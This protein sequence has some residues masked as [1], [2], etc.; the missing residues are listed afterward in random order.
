MAEIRAKTIRLTTCAHHII[1]PHVFTVIF[2]IF[3]K[4][5]YIDIFARIISRQKSQKNQPYKMF[6]KSLTCAD[7]RYNIGSVI[8]A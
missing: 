2:Y 5:L 3:C 4:K 1:Y 6:K 8:R 7:F